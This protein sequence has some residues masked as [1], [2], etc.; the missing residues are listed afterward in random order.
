[1]VE[2]RAGWIEPCS[3]GATSEASTCCRHYR[4]SAFAPV[5]SGLVAAI[6]SHRDRHGT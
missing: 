3:L 5:G 1:M 6:F 4:T 2:R